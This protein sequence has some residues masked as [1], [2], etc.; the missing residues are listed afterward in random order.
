MNRLTRPAALRIAAAI[1]FLAGIWNIFATLP[2][3]MAGPAAAVDT[4]PY[5]VIVS[6]LIFGVIAIVAAYGTWRQ[7]RWGIVLTIIVNVLGGLSAVPGLFIAPTPYFAV[8]AT[9]TVVLSIVV[10]VLCLWRSPKPATPARR[11]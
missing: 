2:Y 1:S 4:P 7:Q 9:F 3:V 8:L 5:V 6:G 10:V 11:I